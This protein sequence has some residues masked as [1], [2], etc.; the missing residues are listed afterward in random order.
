MISITFPDDIEAKLAALAARS[1]RPASSHVTEAVLEYL[2]D[3]EDLE[4]AR[5][6]WDAISSGRAKTIPLADVMRDY[7]LDH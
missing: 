2:A 6:E 5:K 7:D 4:I 1:G 3:L